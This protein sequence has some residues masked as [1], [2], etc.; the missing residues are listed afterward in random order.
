LYLAAL[1]LVPTR[2]WGWRVLAALLANTLFDVRWGTPPVLIAGFFCGNTIQAL[3][4]AWL[5]RR[6]VSEKLPMISLKEFWALLIY[7]TLIGPAPG[8]VIASTALVFTGKSDSL[9]DAWEGLYASNIVANLVL[10]PFLLVWFS[11]PDRERNFLTSPW[12][13]AELVLLLAATSA[14]VC[15]VL[16]DKGGIMSPYKVL[17]VP[18]LLYAGLRLDRRGATAVCLLV[19]LI[20]LILTNHF[21][22]GATPGQIASGEAQFILKCNLILIP[23]V[24]LLPCIVLEERERTLGRLRESEELL[25]TAF[26]S[27]TAGVGMI[28][29]SGRFL[30]VNSMLC[31]M[32]GYEREELERLTFTDV[33]YKD[34]QHLGA[35]LLAGML[36]GKTR[37]G[38]FEKRYVHK[39]GHPIWSEV[40]S[41]LVEQPESGGRCII[42][43]IQD[44][45]ERRRAA[46]ALQASEN[47][48]RTLI[49]KAPV[50]VSISR[51]GRTIYVNQK[52]LLLYGFNSVDELVG[53]P[54][55]EQWAPEFRPMIEE[56]A[57]QRARGLPV[58]SAYEGIGQRKDGSQ[59]SVHVAVGIV[60]LPDGPASLAFLAD[61]TE[62]KESEEALELFRALIDHADDAI[63]VLDPKTGRYL[64]VSA[65]ATEFHGYTREEFLDFT[66]FDIDT[67]I[68]A[69]G[70]A[71]WDANLAE[72]KRHGS[73]VYE[74]EHRRKDGSVFPVEVNATYVRLERDYVLAV[75]RDITER[76]QMAD[77]L[78]QAQK[79]EAIG[80]LAGGV[81]H[82]FNNI[83][84][85]I[86]MQADILSTLEDVPPAI[87][88]GLEQIRNAS[89]RA[90][91][92]TRQLL[93][94]SRK[95]VMQARDLDL[96]D[97]VTSLAKMLQRLIREDV[98]L[99]LHLHP[100][101]LLTHAD[102]GMLDQILLNLAVNARDAMPDGGNLLIETGAKTVDENFTPIDSEAKPGPYVSLSVTDTGDGIAPDI[103]P[104]IFEP[105]F[106][107]KEPG[108]GT[109]L[110]LAT[111]FGIVKQHGGFIEVESEPGK[112]T[113]FQIFLPA[114]Q[115][116][117]GSATAASLSMPHGGNETILLV[118]DEE[119]VRLLTRKILERRGYRVLECANG[120]EALKLWELNRD[121]ISVLLT[122]LVMPS[123][124]SGS[125]LARRL[126]QEKPQIKVIFISGYSPDF[127]GGETELRLGDNFLQKP[128]APDLLLETIR[129]HLDG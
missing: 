85:V 49:E 106:T 5:I 18:F 123:N 14:A 108:K 50:A 17:L 42:A 48:F 51:E 70:Q 68:E 47:R 33:T 128:F 19:P 56:R 82:D 61:I 124:L 125:A 12:R 43:F 101:P 6:F 62:K 116:F 20:T 87:Q 91:N 69:G 127:A 26:E 71:L 88:E 96:N 103:V 105:F 67:A 46:E 89:D 45:T 119:P 39:D 57:Q 77:Q 122:D 86:L 10:T 32:L 74:S 65:K 84:A 60:E 100:A 15:Y 104:H 2:E 73:Q 72:I 94:F 40:M 93:L 112:G 90:G 54:V 81:A 38:Q 120:V 76:R 78:R 117:P 118:E 31:K 9:L 28:D 36:A 75:V 44:I 27:T 79:M 113:R 22:T 25:R 59:F 107:T 55:S 58:P 97:V 109:G 11:R 63:E 16:L 34:D 4:G 102:A 64:D 98:R 83:L 29:M 129:R 121:T 53:Q 3:T 99:Q 24:G 115:T 92:L 13:V 23:L 52:Y 35:N 80:Q 30:H 41:S 66:I 110:G 95:Q 114:C 8:A 7:G 111:V 21:E 37:S 126:R 1:L